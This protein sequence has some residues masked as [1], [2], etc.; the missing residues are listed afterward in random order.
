MTETNVTVNSTYKARIFEMVFSDRKELLALYNAVNGTC[1]TDPEMLEINTLKNAIYMSM[2]NDISFIIDSRLSLYEHQSTYSPNLPLRYLFYVSDLY[3]GMTREANLYGKKQVFLPAPRFLI[4]YNGAEERPER[5]ELKLSS[6]YSIVEKEPS[7]ELKATMLNINPGYNE[8]LKATCKTLRDYA[9]YTARVR[10]Y[11][12]IMRLEEAVERAISECIKEGILSD[13]LMA[14]KAEAKKMSIY[15]YD[16]ELHMRQTRE[17]GREEGWEDG[18]CQG[19][20]SG[21]LTE[22]IETI[23]DVLKDLGTIPEDLHQLIMNQKDLSALKQWVKLAAKV[24]SIEDFQ[25]QISL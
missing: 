7:L 23:L 20:T 12:E 19:E 6:S 1:Y 10:K 17:E 13:F 2:H 18:F 8:E 24:E 9:E 22:R 4:F 21:K 5:Q 25:K 14:N 16:E 11:A 3:S 15:E